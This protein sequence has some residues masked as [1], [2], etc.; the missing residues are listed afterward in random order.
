M[1]KIAFNDGWTCRHAGDSGKGKPVTILMMQCWM[2]SGRR[3]AW[4]ALTSAG[5]KDLTM[6]MR[7]NF[8]YR[9]NMRISDLSLNLRESTAMQK[10][11]STG[12][13]QDFVRMDIQIFT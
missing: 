13:E 9:R 10:C 4:E 8:L 7:K 6:C 1:R 11:I 5:L 3:R 2:K 12:K